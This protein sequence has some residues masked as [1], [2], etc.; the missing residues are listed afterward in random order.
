MGQRAV[1]D[2]S[3]LTA[4]D[5]KA[6]GHIPGDNGLP[7]FGHALSLYDKLP[8]FLDAHIGRYGQLSRLGLGPQRGVV[9]THPDHLQEL[10][11]D[12]E[13]RFSNKMGYKETLGR[14]YGGSVI[15]QDFDDH[16]LNRRLFQAAFRNQAL[17]GYVDIMN[18]TIADDVQDWGSKGDILFGRE[19]QRMLINVGARVFFG[20]DDV[21][22]AE[23][24]RLAKAFINI[25]EKGLFSFIKRDIPGLNYHKG[26]QG[27]R[28]LEAYLK[29]T[30]QLRRANPGKDLTSIM[31]QERD[32][33]GDYWPDEVLIPHLS[34]LLFA[35]HDTTA[36]ALSHLMYYL[37]RPENLHL[38]DKLRAL[39][40]NAGT[41]SPDYDHLEAFAEVEWY[42]NESLRLHPS[43]SLFLRRTT[44]ECTLGD[45]A[46]PANTMLWVFPGWAQRSPEY[47]SN[48]ATFDP[49]RFSDERKEHKSH[50]FAFMPFGGGAHKCLGMHVAYLN[51]KLVLF[52][53]LTRYR[54]EWSDGF[55]GGFTYVPI[56]APKK[57]LPLK[58]TAI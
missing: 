11:L 21:K 22:S 36:G 35:A 12:S 34:L 7:L 45:R 23:V 44:R 37:A 41:A 24:E 39:F 3:Y 4:A 6:L 53:M 29:D 28:D 50:S 57:R 40:L 56:P 51:A 9:V 43:A 26:L 47:W 10:L 58:V 33:N 14:F 46:L 38:Q 20:A 31:C 8:S 27:K 5:C 15:T 18:P 17:K 52:H 32:E 13:Q 30:I 54:F 19:I 1:L 49:Y 55:K 48:P 42:I 25:T 2:K 16:R